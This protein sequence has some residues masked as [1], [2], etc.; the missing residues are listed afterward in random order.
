MKTLVFS[1]VGARADPYSAAPNLLLRLRIDNPGGDEIQAIALRVQIQIEPRR[2]HYSSQ[3][4]SSLGELFGTPERWGETLKTLH[5]THAS[6]MVTAFTEATEI[7][8]PVPCTYDFD[9]V[10]SKYLNAIGDGD[11]PILALFSGT[12]FR[13]GDA[14]FEVAQVPWECESRYMLPASVWRDVMNAHF[15][16]SA[17]IRIRKDLFDE[18]Y[19]YKAARALHTWDDALLALIDNAKERS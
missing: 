17:W 2:R 3:E 11:I 8:V 13:H 9:V 18:L 7:D 16:N 12:V 4:E 14:G 19:A 15:P 5:W 6:I 10:A 1:L